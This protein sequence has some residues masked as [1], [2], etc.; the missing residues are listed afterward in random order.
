MLR[1]K[2]RYMSGAREVTRTP[3]KAAIAAWSGSALE[4]YDFAIYGTAAALVFP[5]VFFPAG[6]DTAATLGAFATFGVAYVAR[7]V[8]SFLMGHVGDRLGRKKVLIATLLL[9]GV[10]TFLV[11]CLPTY[12][13]VGLLAPTLLVVLRILQGLSAAGE[14]AG[15]NSMSFE[16]APDNRRGFFT[17]FT[18]SGTQGGQVLA[19]AVFLP[20]AAVL[21]DDALLSWGWRVPFWLSAVMVVVGFIIRRTLDETPEFQ[22]E[23]DR[24]EVPRAPLGILFRSHWQ[25][26]VRVF[27]A[28]FIATVNT[29]FAVFALEF[30]TSDDVGISDTWM[31]WVA[32]VANVVA[33][34]VIPL[35]AMLSDRVGRKPV[36]VTGVVG[37]GLLVFPFLGAIAQ[38][39]EILTMVFGVLLAGFIYSMPNAVWP[40][41]YAEYFPTGVRLSGMAIGTQFGFALAGFTPTI[42]GALLGGDAGNWYKVALFTAG[43]CLLSAVAVLTGPSETH[44]VPTPALGA[45]TR[46]EPRVA[47]GS[48]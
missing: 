32:I 45:G 5:D 34:A 21:P 44:R 47:A 36:F 42:A 25:G 11:G 39:N 29:M 38:A 12:G 35:W 46:P 30:A 41:T 31:L 16:H 10:S 40:A 27:F 37:S 26:V 43:A 48:A 13:Q 33:V 18:L 6:N 28:A 2:D 17:S 23:A 20:L 15:A 1:G 19:P 3:R 9:M 8:G 22:A 14:Q 24:A 4:Y 7:P